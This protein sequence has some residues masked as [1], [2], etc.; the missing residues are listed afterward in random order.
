MAILVDDVI[1]RGH[2]WTRDGHTKSCHMA[3]DRHDQRGLAEL[4]E[5]A[6]RLRMKFRWFQTK[7]ANLPHYDLVAGRRDDA[8]RYGAQEVSAREFVRRCRWS[9]EE[10]K[11]AGLVDAQ[12]RVR[13]KGKRK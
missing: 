7:H 2:R 6:H 5:M 1:D 9:R 11:A 12:T 3:S 13:T 10:M 4:H 8:V